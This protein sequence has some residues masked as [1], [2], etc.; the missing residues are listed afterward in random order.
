MAKKRAKTKARA[1][2]APTGET[3]LEKRKKKHFPKKG[4]KDPKK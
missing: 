3:K 1:G 2:T 4:F